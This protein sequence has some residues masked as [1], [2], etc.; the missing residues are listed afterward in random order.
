MYSICQQSSKFNLDSVSLQ[1]IKNNKQII[2]LNTIYRY[3]TMSWMGDLMP[4]GVQS[5]IKQKINTL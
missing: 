5:K 4:A 1:F 2:N 3:I